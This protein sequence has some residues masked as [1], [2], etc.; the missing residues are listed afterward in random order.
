M[1]KQERVTRDELRGMSVGESRTFYLPGAGQCVSASM[2][3]C[4]LGM[5]VAKD[6]GKNY[7]FGCKCRASQK[8]RGEITITR[9][10]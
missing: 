6:T 7:K 10:Q 2:T 4:Q 3:A 8:M 9:L 1:N 5:E